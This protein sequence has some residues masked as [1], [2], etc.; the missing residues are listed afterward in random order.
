VSGDRVVAYS[1]RDYGLDL[2]VYTTRGSPRVYE[3][4]ITSHRESLPVQWIRRKE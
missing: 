3:V 4:V 2:A 1:D